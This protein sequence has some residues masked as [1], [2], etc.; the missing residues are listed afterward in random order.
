MWNCTISEYS[1]QNLNEIVWRKSEKF[2]NEAQPSF[3]FFTISEDDFMKILKRVR[4]WVQFLINNTTWQNWAC[5]DAAFVVRHCTYSEEFEKL[6]TIWEIVNN[7]KLFTIASLIWIKTATV[8]VTISAWACCFFE[9]MVPDFLLKHWI[10]QPFQMTDVSKIL[11]KWRWN[12]S[13]VINTKVSNLLIFTTEAFTTVN[14]SIDYQ[15]LAINRTEFA[16]P[17]FKT[18]CSV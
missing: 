5:L 12:D 1:F 13:L 18:L 8:T 3:K 16:G 11:V 10:L 17:K 15:L 4:G 7:F 14:W 9:Q 2:E 6:W